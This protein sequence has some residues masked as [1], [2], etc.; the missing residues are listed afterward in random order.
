ML[1]VNLLTATSQEYLTSCLF[2]VY[3]KCLCNC[4][5][6][7]I[8]WYMKA[9]PSALLCSRLQV[10]PW[11]EART[12]WHWGKATTWLVKI[13]SSKR[14]WYDWMSYL[15]MISNQYTGPLIADR[16][17]AI[18]SRLQGSITRTLDNNIHLNEWSQ[19]MS[20]QELH[21]V[22]TSQKGQRWK[23]GSRSNWMKA[24]QAWR[25]S[26]NIV[27]HCTVKVMFCWEYFGSVGRITFSFSMDTTMIIR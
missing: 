22:I 14:V 24:S 8:I 4:G 10:K 17:A 7:A 6:L 5:C 2:R 9:L 21:K 12:S 1:A 16:M 20:T 13:N 15:V 23:Q 3:R 18:Y 11:N 19:F 27:V 26:H 25:W